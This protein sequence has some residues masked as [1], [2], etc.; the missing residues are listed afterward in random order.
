MADRPTDAA[1]G[2]FKERFRAANSQIQHPAGLRPGEVHEIRGF[3]RREPH[4]RPRHLHQGIRQG[5][6]GRRGGLPANGV[7]GDGVKPRL[8]LLHHP[9][10]RDGDAVPGLHGFDGGN[11]QIQILS[12]GE[13]LR[14]LL[15]EGRGVGFRP[16][17]GLLHIAGAGLAPVLIVA[18]GPEGEPH[19]FDIIEDFCRR[20]ALRHLHAETGVVSQAPG[21]VDVEEAVCP[22]GEAQIPVG[23]VGQVGGGIGKPYLQLPGHF[24]RLDEGHQIIPGGLRPGQDVKIFLLLH[25]GEGGA[26][27]IPGKVPAAA[28]GD[29]PRIQGVRHDGAGGGA[30][31]VVELDGLAGGEMHTAYLVLAD[32]PGDESQFFRCYPAGRHPQAQH[33]GGTALL[34]VAAVVAGKALVG[35]LVQLT[36]VK[37]GS[38]FL[39]SGQILLPGFRVNGLHHKFLL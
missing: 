29:N 27:D 19:G 25:P 37:G 22:G 36:G 15:V 13:N 7:P 39:K 8:L 24:L 10:V 2:G 34:R 33:V 18:V 1:D 31:Q 21:A 14:Q 35:G 5:A 30:V 6:E 38:F 28:Y 17:Q 23:G 3:V 26:H 11:V 20:D 4:F 9:P 32:G 12:G 16:S